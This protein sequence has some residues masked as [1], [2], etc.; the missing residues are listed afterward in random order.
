LAFLVAASL[1]PRYY[2]LQ[3]IA[4]KIPVRYEMKIVVAMD[5]FKSSINPLILGVL[6]G[7]MAESRSGPA[8]EA[9]I[10]FSI[11]EVRT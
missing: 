3:R 11:Y 6:R 9:S 2:K 10:Q 5:S 4:D 7:I 8:P 1:E